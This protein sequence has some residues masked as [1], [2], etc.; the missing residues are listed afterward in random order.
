MIPDF[1]SLM[2]P[3]LE[4]LSDGG[5]RRTRDL[6]EAMSDRFELTDEEREA[7]LPSGRQRLMSN[8]VN[9][10]ITHLFQAGLLERP[11]RGHVAIT[12]AGRGVLAERPDRVDMTV[13]RGFE[14][15]RAFRS[16][17]RTEDVS[18]GED[19]SRPVEPQDE[20]ASPQDLLAQ[21]V[22]ENEAAV[23][24]ELLKRALALSPTEF[25]RLV[26]RLLERM[27]YGRFGGVE[28]SGR[29]GDAGID[30]IISQDP[31][32][33]DRIYL[34]AKRYGPDQSV[35]RPAIQGFVGALMGAQGDRGVFITTSSF[36][37]GARTEA[38]RVNA[39][40]ELIDGS[41]LAQLMLTHGV[42][43]QP[44]IT[45]ALHQLDEDFF[46]TL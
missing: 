23:E 9:W 14:S 16:R 39:R 6:V 37:T 33:L 25:E 15:Y 22:R 38:D 5:V 24:G 36:S 8:R 28:H 32:G 35:Q 46:E 3:L 19:H 7:M 2:R 17:S 29:A 11:T 30:G 1:Q 21:A 41:R 27:G 45:V 42:G 26:L 40:I 44:E 4:A 20:A 18:D 31:L 12:E 13:L 10:S 34:Q 43:V